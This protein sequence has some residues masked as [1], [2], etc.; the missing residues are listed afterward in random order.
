MIKALF[1]VVFLVWVA[2]A[3]SAQ[4]ARDGEALARAFDAMKN[5]DWRAALRSAEAISPV[6]RDI[7]E[8]HRL[9]A[10]EG[11]FD[12]ALR[13][14]DRRPDWP[15]L[16]YLR[17]RSED[18]LPFG[19]RAD[20]VIG[21]FDGQHP[22]TGAG[23]VALIAAFRSKGMDADAEAEALYAWLTHRLS[24][25]DE[26]K[27]LSWYGRALARYHTERLD[28]LL[29]RGA[30]S[31]AKRMQSLV[32][33]GWWALAQAR[34]ALRADQNG[35]DALVKNVPRDLSD[36]PGLQFERMQWRARKGRNED[37]IDLML[38]QG[39]DNLGQP[40]SWA[41]W[42]RSFVRSEMRAGRAKQA[43]DLASNHGLESGFAFADLEWLSGYI[44]LTYLDDP[45]QA[46][47]H[48]LRFRG[49]V[50]TPIS[51]G[52]AG[53]WEGRAHEAM[54][55]TENARLA[56]AFGAEYQTSF[57]GLLA[58]EKA[59]KPMDP[60]LYAP[61]PA[62]DLGNASFS[63]NSVFLAALLLDQ[64][65][66]RVLAARFFTHL[67]ESLAPEDIIRLG[68]FILARNEPHYATVIGK[69]AAAYGTTV[70]FVYYPVA[71]LGVDPMP[72]PTELALSIARRESE[73]DP[74]VTSG[75]GARGLMQVMPA[76]A[77]AVAGSLDIPYSASRLLEDAQYNARIGTAYL[78]ELMFMFN[79]NFVMVSAGYN[80]GPGRPQAW[81]ESLGDPRLGDMD[82]VDWIE[83]IPFN[84]TRNYVMRVAESVVVYRA[85]LTGQPQPMNLSQELIAMPGHKRSAAIGLQLRPRAR[86]SPLTD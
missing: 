68:A 48:F 30:E 75:V 62:V 85:R 16:A 53:Y 14:L 42:R 26:T 74:G 64:A 32:S 40:Q 12:S 69:R 23:A 44:S 81:M 15:G 8:W 84:E 37:A 83:H 5:E 77:R 56:Y 17:E 46:L 71:D 29:W 19:G 3:A 27:L 79:G 21:F 67:T 2:A 59:G 55:D 24:E 78:D 39:P 41:G 11:D 82:V 35:V 4:T 7:I 10:K 45:E 52:R 22:Q 38:A 18:A 63:G 31:D 58:A 33:Q 1:A 47:G 66:E 72:V 28:M 80:A 9:R 50:D 20:D 65:G 73:F 25:D 34:L 36:H 61:V 86:P 54:G 51:L 6:A 57:Y 70:P 60:A 13:F 49:A 43:Y 76:T